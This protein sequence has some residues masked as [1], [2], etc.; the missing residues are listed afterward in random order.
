M[1]R[2]SLDDRMLFLGLVMEKLSKLEEEG[3]ADQVPSYIKSIMEEVESGDLD[4][5]FVQVKGD[6]KIQALNAVKMMELF[7]QGMNRK[8]FQDRVKKNL[9]I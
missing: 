3:Q 4:S 1:R 5:L 8:D 6:R 2:I 7:F 9:G